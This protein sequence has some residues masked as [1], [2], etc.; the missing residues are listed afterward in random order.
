LKKR[1]IL[2]AVILGGF[3]FYVQA[4]DIGI[5]KSFKYNLSTL[6]EAWKK[7]G[8]FELTQRSNHKPPKEEVICSWIKTSWRNVA[9]SVILNSI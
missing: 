7:I 6:I 2:S 3:I 1:N 4:G 9:Q 5:Y 8:N